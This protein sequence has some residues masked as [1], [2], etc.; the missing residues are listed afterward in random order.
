MRP[1][2]TSPSTAM[3]TGLCHALQQQLC[4]PAVMESLVSEQAHLLLPAQAC[5]RAPK[6]ASPACC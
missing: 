5:Q 6:R 4:A 3:Y 1:V 2:L